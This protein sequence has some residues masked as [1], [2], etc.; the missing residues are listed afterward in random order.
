[1]TYLSTTAKQVAKYDGMIM[2]CIQLLSAP[3]LWHSMGQIIKSL[4]VCVSVVT[5]TVAIMGRFWWNFA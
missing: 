1:M 3:L 5:P 2:C 4:S